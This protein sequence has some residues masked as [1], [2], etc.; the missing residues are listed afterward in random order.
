MQRP[1]LPSRRQRLQKQ[2]RLRLLKLHRQEQIWRRVQ[3]VSPHQPPLPRPPRQLLDPVL[4][5]QPQHKRRQQLLNLLSQRQ[6][7]RDR[8]DLVPLD[9]RDPEQRRLV[10]Q[11]LGLPPLGQLLP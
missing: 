9:R 1:K 10:L 4:L 8:L 3:Q 7:H 11:H 5:L 2:P 6:E